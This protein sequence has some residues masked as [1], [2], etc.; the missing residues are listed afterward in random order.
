VLSISVFAFV[1]QATISKC[2]SLEFPSGGTSA[3]SSTPAG[4]GKKTSSVVKVDD[5]FRK[6]VNNRP[7]R[8]SF[9]VL[10]YHSF[11]PCV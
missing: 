4:G 3:A 8:D 5:L 1:H 11:F 10:L 6:Q 9:S 2:A 7:A